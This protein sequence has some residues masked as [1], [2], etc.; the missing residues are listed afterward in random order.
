[1]GKEEGGTQRE[2][3]EAAVLW[4]S[5]EAAAGLWPGPGAGMMPCFRPL[6]NLFIVCLR[7]Q[8]PE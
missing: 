8:A 7:I 4:V 6:L 3:Q 5:W 2:G 1:M